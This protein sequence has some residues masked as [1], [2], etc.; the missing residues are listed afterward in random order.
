MNS[1]LANLQP[2]PFERL[3]QLLSGITPNPAYSPVSLGLGEPRHATPAIIQQAMVNAVNRTPSGLCAYPA[4]AGEL[5]LRNAFAAWLKRRYGLDLDPAT[6]MLPILGS[7]EALFA[8]TQTV[9]DRTAGIDGQKPLVVSP[10]PFYQIYEG[11]ALLAGAEPRCHAGAVSGISTD[12][13][14]CACTSMAWQLP[15]WPQAP[16]P[17]GWSHSQARTSASARSNCPSPDGPASSQ[18]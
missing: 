18:A 15:Q 11:S 4:T 8:L 16:C 12:R 14:A 3:R 17:L 2:Y 9:V 7:R 5:C 10:N 13:S 6:E 1:L